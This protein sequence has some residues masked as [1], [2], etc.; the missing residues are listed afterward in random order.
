MKYQVNNTTLH[1]VDEGKHSPTLLFLHFWGG[2]SRTWTE[3]AGLLSDRYRTIRYDHRGWGESDKP[4]NGYDIKTL[5]SDAL[6]LIAQLN[7]DSFVLVGHSM[8][9]KVAQYVAARQPKGLRKLILVAPSPA[10]PTIFP[11]EALNNMMNA[12]TTEAGIN[13]TIDQVF[14]AGNINSTIRIRTI[15]DMKKHSKA[16]R[17]SWPNIALSEDASEGL[18]NINVPTLIIAGEKD[19]VDTPARL[20]HEV[21]DRI[22]GSSMVTIPQ[23]GHLMMLQAPEPVAAFIDSF[24]KQ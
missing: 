19:V 5:A 24:A 12:Y 13:K 14:Q 4:D 1:I 21:K 17:I 8:G 16:S 15:E 3:V 9:G 2:S 10:T 18:S 7:L 6:A 11:Q 20:E 22:P 23:V